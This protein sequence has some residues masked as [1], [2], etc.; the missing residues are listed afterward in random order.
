MFAG[1]A[2][3]GLRKGQCAEP[4]LRVNGLHYKEECAY[5]F[6]LSVFREEEF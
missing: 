3:D 5:L 1:T 6:F 2:S 4:G